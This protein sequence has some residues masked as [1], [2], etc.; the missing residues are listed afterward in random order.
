MMLQHPDW[1]LPQ[2]PVPDDR[3]R[4]SGDSLREYLEDF[5]M[6]LL[7][8]VSRLAADANSVNPFAAEGWSS[9]ERDIERLLAAQGCKHAWLC[10]AQA[11]I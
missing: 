9:A 10:C 6:E 8:L 2:P 11:N 4:A 7:A 1:K 5:Q 3:L